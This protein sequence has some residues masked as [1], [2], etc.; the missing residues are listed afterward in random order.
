MHVVLSHGDNLESLPLTLFFLVIY[1]NFDSFFKWFFEIHNANQ[2]LL[3]HFPLRP[4]YLWINKKGNVLFACGNEHSWTQKKISLFQLS[5]ILQKDPLILWASR[6]KQ[7]IVNSFC[8][9]FYFF[10]YLFFFNPCLLKIFNLQ[11][12][13]FRII[14]F[15][16][17]PL[18]PQKLFIFLLHQIL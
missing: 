2:F 6:T 5:Q 14:L 12:Q 3:H 9:L 8:T 7:R 15:P 18:E 13:L 4:R 10:I 11:C 17:K 16:L 1:F